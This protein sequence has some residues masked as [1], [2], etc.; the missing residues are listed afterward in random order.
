MI[1]HGDR[2]FGVLRLRFEGTD[3]LDA[4][5][6]KQA[7]A[8]A[9]ALIDGASDVVIDLG[10]IEFIDSTG[11]SVLVSVLKAARRNGREAHFATISPGVR[12]VL[13]VIKLDRIF[14][15][16]DDPGTAA[17]ALR[18]RAGSPPRRG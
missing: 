8:E 4:L 2:S 18:A 9:L 14:D 11:I 13:E 3:A 16:H 6:A 10:G 7:K 12:S 17:A 5:V 1:V 15:L